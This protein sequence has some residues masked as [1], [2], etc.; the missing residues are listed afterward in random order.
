MTTS[1]TIRRATAA[2]AGRVA[3]LVATAFAPL[4]AVTWLVPEPADRQRIMT[5]NLRIFVDHAVEFG[6]IDLIDDAPAAAVWFPRTDPIPE[7]A[8]YERRL[9]AACGPWTERFQV[10]DSLFE[11]NHPDAPHYHLALLAVAPELQ[12]GGLGSALLRRQHAELDATATPAYLEA[13]SSGSHD[14][15]LRHG[16][17]SGEPFTLPDGTPFWPMWR[18]PSGV[19]FMP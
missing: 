3:E 4:D 11:Q 9:A 12:G 6:H 13:S 19:E 15:Y 7:P 1:V 5:A 18:P 17:E 2:D 14:L 8:D 10:L 16:Y